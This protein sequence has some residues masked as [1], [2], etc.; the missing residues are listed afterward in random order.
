MDG[1]P[2]DPQGRDAGRRDDDEIFLKFL[3]D[4]LDQRRFSRTRRTGHEENRRRSVAHQEI[5]DRLQLGRDLILRSG[6]L[7][8]LMALYASL[9][10]FYRIEAVSHIHMCRN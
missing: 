7:I 5:Q 4:D 8:H 9:Q 2:T 3:S 10:G 1:L 6:H